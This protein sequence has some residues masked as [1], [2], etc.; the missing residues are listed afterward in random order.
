MSASSRRLVLVVDD[1]PELQGS[2]HARLAAMDFEVRSAL[3]YEAALLHLTSWRPHLV[4]V[5]VGLPT[6]SGYELCEHIRGPLGLANVPI[7]MTCDS[8]LPEDMANA[9]VA[10]ANAF[11]RKPFSMREFSAYVEALVNPAQ[12]SERGVR[13]LLAWP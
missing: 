4:C 12:Q 11:L 1:D 5:D 8:E 9:E 6:Q 10:G 3:H 2:M 13:R 7:L